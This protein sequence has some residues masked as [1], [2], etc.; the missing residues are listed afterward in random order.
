MNITFLTLGSRGDVQPYVALGKGFID[1]G[2][3][4]T[5]CTGKT[6]QPFIE[7]YGIRFVKAEADLMEI[8]KTKEGNAIF[9]GGRL[10]IKE[11]MNFVKNV[12]NPLFRKSFDDFLVASERADVIICHPKAMV[13]Y[14]I[15]NYYNIP[16]ISM[17]PVPILFPT[18]EFPNLAIAPNK[19][20]GSML[21][22]LTY[23]SVKFSESSSMKEINNFRKEKLGMKKRRMGAYAHYKKQPIIYP[24]SPALFKDV[25]SWNGYVDVTG[26]LFLD[27]NEKGLEPEIETFLAQGESPWVVTFSS[28]PAEGLE[29]IFKNVLKKR[30]ERAIFLVGN[31]NMHFDDENILCKPQIPHRLIF[32]RAKGIIHHGG[33]GTMAEAL[34]SGKPQQII[35]FNVDQ[36]FWAHRLYQLGLMSK[37][38]GVKAITEDALNAIFDDMSQQEHILNAQK[39]AE[40]LACENGI[41]NAIEAIERTVWCKG[42]KKEF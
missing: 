38:V 29:S 37:P 35:P 7:S 4:V 31:S 26:F 36:P 5:I 32:K 21:N 9:N 28:M 22:R 15:A 25:T 6:F 41:Q 27:N 14:D 24:I 19:N 8:L 3:E 16:C 33:V 12:I 42:H 30:G 18:A 40:K 13:A 17:P 10:G 39:F 20:F 23:F 34:V 1:R 2:H 11:T